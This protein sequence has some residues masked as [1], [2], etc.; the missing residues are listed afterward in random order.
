MTIQ[1]STKTLFF[2]LLFTI[3]F[4]CKK[5]SETTKPEIITPEIAV[6]NFKKSL[7]KNEIDSIFKRNLFNG[8][9][10]V[11]QDS[12]LL[13]RKES[14]FEDF[15]LKTPI[16]ENTIFAIGS[17][18]KQFTAVMIL[19]Q[20]EAGKLQ[21][22]DSVSKF[23]SEFQ[24]PEFEKITV[25]QLMN[26]TSGISD[27]GNGLQSKP[28]EKF[29]YSN[30]GFYF[31]GKI[32]EKAS[33]KSYDENAKEM[34][35]NIGLKNTFTADN[36]SGAN[37]G[38]AYTGNAKNFQQIENMPKRL[39]DKSISIAAGGILSTINDL[40][41]WNQKLYGGKIINPENLQKF[42]AQSAERAH[43]IFGKMGYGL[44]IMMT[45]GNPKSYFHS[46]YVKGSPSLNIYYPE[47][48]T[49]VI[50]LSNIADETKGKTAFFKPHQEM[51]NFAD[52]VEKASK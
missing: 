20:N 36:F 30:K 2:L 6:R 11:F 8:S 44:G 45:M 17:I 3:F 33:G 15:T 10:A 50:I 25:E 48:K 16:S 39:A 49:S 35:Q 24:T 12:I 34:F 28:G 14:G 21:L 37:F 29:N 42:L 1:N 52:V 46:G 4:S 5:E 26:H 47:T 43:P 13:T 31:L 41:L 22:Q 38:G 51:K 9:I 19:K 18:S 40:H 7:Y 23:L 32:L 27:F